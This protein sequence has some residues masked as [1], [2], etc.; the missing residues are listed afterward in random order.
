MSGV[1]SAI[2]EFELG[3][4]VALRSHPTAPGVVAAYK[5]SEGSHVQYMVLW[6][7]GM[8]VWH[9]AHEIAP[10]DAKQ[11]FTLE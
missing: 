5:I 4:V 8:I 9:E 11:D 10:H 1:V 3:D 7:P 6:E 2:V